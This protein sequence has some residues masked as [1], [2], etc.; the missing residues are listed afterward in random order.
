MQVE[1][2][3]V[4]VIVVDSYQPYTGEEKFETG[5]LIATFLELS[6]YLLARRV[7]FLIL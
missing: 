6:C 2:S 4:G 5:H 7:Q 3:A 1:A